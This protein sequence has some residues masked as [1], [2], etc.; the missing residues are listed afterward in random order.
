MLCLISAGKNRV[1]GLRSEKELLFNLYNASY[2][3]VSCMPDKEFNTT[4][5][6]IDFVEILQQ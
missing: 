3:L 2:F 1:Q 5:P 6:G 4:V